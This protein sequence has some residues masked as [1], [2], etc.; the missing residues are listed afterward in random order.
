MTNFIEGD[1]VVWTVVINNNPIELKGD[2]SSITGDVMCCIGKDSD[3]N[4]WRDYLSI[5]DE[6]INRL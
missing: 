5:N 1:K 4:W 6:N 2:V 3:G